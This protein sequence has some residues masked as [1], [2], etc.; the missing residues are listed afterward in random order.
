MNKNKFINV[1]KNVTNNMP[2]TASWNA[3]T[4]E[5]FKTQNQITAVIINKVGFF[6]DEIICANVSETKKLIYSL[7]LF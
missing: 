2:L 3:E 5:R 4:Q 1:E 7:V 6:K